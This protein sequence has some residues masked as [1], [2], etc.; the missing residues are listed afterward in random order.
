MVAQDD[1][2]HEDLEER[3]TLVPRADAP[4][5]DSCAGTQGA[6]AQRPPARH[7]VHLDDETAASRGASTTHRASRTSSAR[8]EGEASAAL[9]GL[10]TEPLGQ[11]NPGAGA[12][13]SRPTSR[14]APRW[15]GLEGTTR[16][17]RG[18]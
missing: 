13:R 6:G 16:W 5:I 17:P 1:Q 4:L 10:H 14:V 7:A 8:G 15:P 12:R 18:A 9:E 11:L 2:R 3:E